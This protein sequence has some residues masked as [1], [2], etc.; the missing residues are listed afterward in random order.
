MKINILRDKLISQIDK[1]EKGEISLDKEMFKAV[2]FVF[3]NE[4]RAELSS[5]QIYLLNYF[6]HVDF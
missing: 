5:E 4:N 1:I 3:E 6:F 2:K